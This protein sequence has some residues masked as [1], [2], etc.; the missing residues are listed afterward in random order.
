MAELLKWNISVE[1]GPTASDVHHI[2]INA[3]S[4]ED[5]LVKAKQWA[6]DNNVKNPTFSEPYEDIYDE[7]LEWTPEEEEEFLHIVNNSGNIGED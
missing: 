3:T 4:S 1:C 6:E 5:A 7:F 2:I